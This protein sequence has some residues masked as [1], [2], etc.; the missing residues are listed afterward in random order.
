[1][2]TCSLGAMPLPALSSLSF[3]VSYGHPVAPGMQ[4]A[5]LPGQQAKWIKAEFPMFSQHQSGVDSG[6]PDLGPM[7]IPEPIPRNGGGI[8]SLPRPNTPVA[9]VGETAHFLLSHME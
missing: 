7:P 4:A 2:R 3:C 6:W 1:M 5:T 9:L 8:Y